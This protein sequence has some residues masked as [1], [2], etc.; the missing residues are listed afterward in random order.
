MAKR[1]KE[2]RNKAL[3]SAL[4]LSLALVFAL[5]LFPSPAQAVTQS[6]IDALKKERD[7]IAAQRE[8]KQA[9]VDQLE[10][11]HASV[12]ERKQAM[13][14]R[15][16]YTQQQIQIVNDEIGLYDQMIADKAAEVDE[17]L[18]LEQEQMEQEV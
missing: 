9:V 7:E 1:D 13:D 8:E 3:R 11:Q 14:E 5:T 16:V 12:Q 17:A 10:E 18:R 4:S 15:N 6:E 2:M